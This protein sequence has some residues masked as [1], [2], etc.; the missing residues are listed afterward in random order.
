[1]RINP[2]TAFPSIHRRAVKLVSSLVHEIGVPDGPGLMLICEDHAGIAR[3]FGLPV[4]AI[5]T[6]FGALDDGVIVQQSPMGTTVSL[7]SLAKARGAEG[8][9]ATVFRQIDAFVPTAVL[10]PAR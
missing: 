3:R 2:V 7:E 5:R 8:L 1:M 4:P 10:A 9:T 6:L